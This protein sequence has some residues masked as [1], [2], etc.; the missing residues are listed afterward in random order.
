MPLFYGI[1]KGLKCCFGLHQFL[2]HLKLHYKLGRLDEFIQKH[3]YDFK[4]IGRPDPTRAS[5]FLTDMRMRCQNSNRTTTQP[6]SQPME[7]LE[8]SESA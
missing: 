1:E 3:L 4:R 2:D 6:S 5:D 8:M 7:S